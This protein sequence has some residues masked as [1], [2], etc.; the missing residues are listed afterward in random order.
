MAVG[1]RDGYIEFRFELGN[2]VGM[3]KSN[4]TLSLGES[5]DVTLVR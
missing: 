3:A 1:L 5:H 4:S 2:G